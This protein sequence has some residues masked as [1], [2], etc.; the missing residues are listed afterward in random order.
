MNSSPA[1]TPLIDLSRNRFKSVPETAGVYVIFWFRDGKPVPIHR[2]LGVDERGVIYIGSTKESL[3]KRLR[4]LWISIEMAYGRRIRKRYP[5]TFGV[6]LLYTRFHTVI[7]DDE[8]MIFYNSFNP[9]EADYQEK[10][11]LFEYTR[12]YGEPPPLN[13]KVGRQYLAIVDLGLHGKS[14]LVGE[15]DRELREV[16]GL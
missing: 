12:R 9:D 8:L 16:L 3:K 10:L 15:L 4:R 5:H 13:L 7:R 1:L 14:R 2:I 6:S 11:A